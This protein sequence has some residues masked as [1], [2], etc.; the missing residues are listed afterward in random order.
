MSTTIFC[1]ENHGYKRTKHGRKGE[2][3]CGFCKGARWFKVYNRRR[4]LRAKARQDL[5]EARKEL[6]EA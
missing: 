6:Q 2:C 4:V 3:G 5:T 1:A